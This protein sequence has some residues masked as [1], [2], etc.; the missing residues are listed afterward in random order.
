MPIQNISKYVQINDF[1]LLEYEFNRDGTTVDLS[2]LGPKVSVTSVGTKQY[3]NNSTAIGITNN[4]LELN[5]VATNTLRSTW[6]NSETTSQFNQ[7]F[8]SSIS[9]ATTTEYEHDTVKVHVISGYNFDDIVGF[10][11]QVR[12]KDTS[13]NM[14]DL[15]NF[16]YLKQPVALGNSNVVK[17]SSNALYLGNKFYDKYIE[18]K[19]PSVYALGN[20]LK[21]AGTLGL[22]LDIEQNSDVYLTYS[23]IPTI[24]AD[25]SDSTFVLVENVNFQLPVTSVADNFN[26]FIAQSTVGDFIEYYA[27]WA[28]QI[29]GQYMGDIESGRISLTTSNNPNDNYQEFSSIYGNQA[30]KWVLI[31]E[32]YVYEQLPGVDGGSSILTQKFSFTQEDNF[33]LPNYFRPVLKNADIDSSYTIQYIIRLTNR[34]DGTQIIRRSSFASTDP[35]KYGLK[36]TRINVENIIPYKVFNKLEAEKGNVVQGVS[37]IRTKYVKVF[38]DTSSI[39]LNEKNEV[40]PQGLGPI[41]LKNGDSVYK[42]K[43]EKFNESAGQREN[44]DLS[45]AYNYILSFKLKDNSKIDVVPTYSTNMNTTI[46][47]IEFKINEDQI[48]TILSQNIKDYSIKVKNPDGTDY[49]FYEGNVYSYAK[50][51][52]AKQEQAN[53]VQ[54]IAGLN[55]QLVTSQAQYNNLLNDY[56]TLLAETNAAKTVVSTEKTGYTKPTTRTSKKTAQPSTTTVEQSKKIT[57]LEAD[58]ARLNLENRSYKSGR[59][60]SGAGRGDT[61]ERESPADEIQ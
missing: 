3:Y 55:N 12:A 17:F 42:F 38:F 54:Q 5:S 35:K 48:N 11:L 47:E 41:Y 24:Q 57:D 49:T 15:S 50:K 4:I 60:I 29:I 6:F 37:N 51:E 45:G 16:S 30:A 34:M 13:A 19:I 8:D 27:T 32:L 23:T 56:N 44:I 36:F 33:S 14:V 18:F 10:L 58:N 59:N 1:I 40:F 25:A 22:G 7:Y 28:D 20:D 53:Y 9:V 43:F 21:S 26:A 2:S 31:H 52:E 39:L 46:G 61:L